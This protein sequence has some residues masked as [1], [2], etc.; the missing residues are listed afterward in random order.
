M[1]KAIGCLLYDVNKDMVV[2][3]QRSSTSSYPLTWGLWGGKIETNETPVEALRR[4]LSEEIG[5]VPNMEMVKPIDVFVSED[6]NF[7][8]YSY[9][10]MVQDLPKITINARETNDSV[11]LPFDSVLKI[12][13]HPHTKTTIK[14][15]K[16][17]IRGFINDTKKAA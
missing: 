16:A 15:K 7:V 2:L 4:E 1:I 6:G 12:D 14:K 5:F 8:Y 10:V 11:W 9:L 17:I 3:Q 13:L